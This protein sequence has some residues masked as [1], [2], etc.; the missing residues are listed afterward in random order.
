MSV[1]Q[2]VSERW[3]WGLAKGVHSWREILQGDASVLT[4]VIPTHIH[5]SA[6]VLG[7]LFAMHTMDAHM[8]LLCTGP[9]QTREIEVNTT[10]ISLPA[11]S[12]SRHIENP[13]FLSV[14]RRGDDD[15]GGKGMNPEL[16][17][18]F[19]LPQS[20][21]LCPS[22][23]Y[24]VLSNFVADMLGGQSS[25]SSRNLSGCF[26]V[27]TGQSERAA[28]KIADA[29]LI[30][31]QTAV[32]THF[33]KSRATET[34]AEALEEAAGLC[35]NLSCIVILKGTVA[36]EHV[37]DAV[38]YVADTRL[39]GACMLVSWSTRT[40]QGS[41]KPPNSQSQTGLPPFPPSYRLLPL[42]PRNLPLALSSPLTP[43]PLF[44][45]K[46]HH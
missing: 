11:S 2:C 29:M 8:G 33:S 43:F 25:A 37:G 34:D 30:T 3:G 44:V 10:A 31:L 24:N 27:T 5:A 42:P 21:L 23:G 15:N 1:C 46:S 9:K 36:T 12:S 13:S 14:L 40:D 20:Y 6:E 16:K 19:L 45:V 18:S 4:C 28:A 7:S 32:L 41:R 39:S 26:A 38:R 22:F 17:A 35:A